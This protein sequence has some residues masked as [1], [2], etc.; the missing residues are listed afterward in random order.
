MR[1]NAYATSGTS[2]THSISWHLCS[3]C[4]F[5]FSFVKRFPDL[6]TERRKAE[7]RSGLVLSETGSDHLHVIAEEVSRVPELCIG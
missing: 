5:P 2:P 1:L 6:L 4:F 3:F 7:E